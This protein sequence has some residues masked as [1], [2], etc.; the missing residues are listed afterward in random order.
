M[1]MYIFGIV[2]KSV[3]ITA[4]YYIIMESYRYNRYH[5]KNY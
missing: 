2:Y 5:K 1:Q 4:L 3:Y